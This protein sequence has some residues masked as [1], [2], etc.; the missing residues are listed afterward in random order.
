MVRRASR[1]DAIGKLAHGDALA[2]LATIAVN[3]WRALSEL[4]LEPNGYY[5]PDWELAVNASA[6]GRTGVSALCAYGDELALIGLM[7][8]IS[9]RQAYKLPLPALVS[10]HP[11]GTLCTPL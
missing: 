11:Y 10:G 8:V 7:P 1:D 9:L 6:R 2:P 3:Q 5:L 4:T